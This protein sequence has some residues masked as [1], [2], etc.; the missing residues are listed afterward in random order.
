MRANQHAIGEIDDV[1]V[2]QADAAAQ[3]GLADG[4]KADKAQA[5][6]PLLSARNLS[7]LKSLTEK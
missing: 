5:F 4:P 1:L 2:E 3:D 7:P 6:K